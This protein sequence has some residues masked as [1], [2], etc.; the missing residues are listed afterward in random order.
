MTPD[1]TTLLASP[2]CPGCRRV[3]GRIDR[4]PESGED[5]PKPPLGSAP[6]LYVWPDGIAWDGGRR[7][8]KGMWALI[9]GCPAGEIGGTRRAPIPTVRSLTPPAVLAWLGAE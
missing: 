7:I 4:T 8:S 2:C 6:V 1:L 5:A 3:A 9:C